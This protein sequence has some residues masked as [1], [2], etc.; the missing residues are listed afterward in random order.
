VKSKAYK[1]EICDM[2]TIIMRGVLTGLMA[3]YVFLA[4]M[5]ADLGWPSL[6]FKWEMVER[7]FLLIGASVFVAVGL[8]ISL[9]FDEILY[10]D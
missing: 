8:M 5:R 3:L 4:Y 9:A 7:F 1:P 10:G 2:G 6:I